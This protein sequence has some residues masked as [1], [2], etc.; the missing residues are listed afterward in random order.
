M[1][2]SLFNGFIHEKFIPFIFICCFSSLQLSAAAHLFACN[3]HLNIPLQFSSNKI[4]SNAHF[5]LVFRGPAVKKLTF[6]CLFVPQPPVAKKDP[7]AVNVA[8]MLKRTDSKSETHT[9]GSEL[10]S[11]I[12]N[13]SLQVIIIIKEVILNVN[14]M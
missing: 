6:Y 1:F 3:C 2:F 10:H 9:N 5:L 13:V 7:S 8:H 12:M 4:G 14:I 11:N